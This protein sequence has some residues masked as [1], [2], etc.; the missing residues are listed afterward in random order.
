MD[1]LTSYKKAVEKELDTF[2]SEKYES[3]KNIDPYS[4]EMVSLL[5]D[6]TL[7]G[8]KRIRGALFYHGYICFSEENKEEILKMSMAIEL[9]QSYLLIHDDIMDDDD[10]RR[11]KPS[12]HKSYEMIID[13]K[14]NVEDAKHIGKSLAIVAGDICCAFSNEIFAKAKIPDDKKIK[15]ITYL[16]HVVHKVCYGQALDILSCIREDIEHKDIEKINNLKTS[17]YT[18]TGPLILGAIVAGADEDEIK[19]LEDIF[20]PLGEAFQLQDDILG[21]FGTE[22]KLGKPIGSD[23]REGKKTLLILKAIENASKEEKEFIKKSLGT[24]VSKKEIEK[25]R[26]IVKNTGSLDYCKKRMEEITYSSRSKAKDLILRDEG[27]TFILDLYSFLE[28]RDN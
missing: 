18:I 1:T 20:S 17:T 3:A 16:N 21:L 2:F 19:K 23:I 24:C 12:L 14:F 15:A 5:K 11:G 26:E 27:K 25:I 13:K 22:E 6:F 4:A 28:K 7:R 10:F 8:G 9:L